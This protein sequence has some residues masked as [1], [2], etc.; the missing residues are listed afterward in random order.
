MS[1]PI[2]DEEMEQVRAAIFAGRKIEAIKLYREASGAGLKDAKDFVEALEDELRKAA[3]E[4]FTAP[5]S[6]SG[7]GLGMVFLGGLVGM[8]AWT[9]S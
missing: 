6:K 7:C 3:P 5:P 1:S 2:S 8:L 9:W 4:R